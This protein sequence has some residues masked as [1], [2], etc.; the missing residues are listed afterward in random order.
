MHFFWLQLLR[1]FMIIIIILKLKLLFKKN[2]FY[3]AHKILFIV[4]ISAS[5]LKY[6]NI[7]EIFQIL[8]RQLFHSEIV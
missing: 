7:F 3:L 5:F 6:L 4:G 2:L 8:S 1:C